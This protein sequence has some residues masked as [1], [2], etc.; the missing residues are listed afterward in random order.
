M[1]APDPPSPTPPNIDA[2]TVDDFGEEWAAFDQTQLSDADHRDQFWDYFQIFPFETLSA[3][4]EGFDLGCGSGRWASEV[5]KRVGKLHC[6][7]PSA[8]ALD[9]ARRRMTHQPNVE[10]HLAGA[11]SIPVSDGSQDFGYCLGVLHHIPDTRRALGDC[12]RK[13]RPRAPFLL[14]IYYALDDRPAWFR[15]L[16]RLTD[17]G[18]R[19]I[20]RLPFRAKRAVAEVI[21]ATV[22]WPIARGAALAE[23]LGLDVHDWPLAWYRNGSFYRMRTDA[24]DRFGTR[25]EQRFTKEQI[26]QMMREAGLTDINF[27][28]R[29]PFWVAC[30]R[31]LG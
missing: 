19:A 8:K 14:Y 30:G 17:V 7:D 4:A 2:A 31:R 5:A 16:W 9:V 10:F 18:R 22:Y 25:L 12:V 28:D 21:A 13:L 6:I 15:T 23:T 20:S 27:S 1:I 29:A 26:D 11:D 24:L 3:E